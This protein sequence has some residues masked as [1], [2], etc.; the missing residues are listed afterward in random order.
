MR[1]TTTI[2]RSIS[3]FY[4]I[5]RVIQIKRDDATAALRA[6]S[7]NGAALKSLLVLFLAG[8]KSDLQ[9]C[10]PPPNPLGKASRRWRSDSTYMNH[11]ISHRV[12][13][14]CPI[15]IFFTHF[16]AQY[17]QSILPLYPIS[18]V[19]Q[20]KWNDAT[21]ALKALSC[22]GAALKNLHVPFLNGISLTRAN[23]I[24]SNTEQVPCKEESR[25][26]VINEF[27]WT[28]HA[29]SPS[30]AALWVIE[31]ARMSKWNSIHLAFFSRFRVLFRWSQTMGQPL[32]WHNHATERL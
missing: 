31:H 9:G 13:Q 16:N 24:D 1:K 11:R 22:N 14:Y 7:C 32:W 5:S 29:T 23:K 19:I 12:S 28:P 18:R 2:D 6:L 21:A 3:P 17:D 20:T 4:P 10:P 8:G 27:P 26:F 25:F 15:M 30:R